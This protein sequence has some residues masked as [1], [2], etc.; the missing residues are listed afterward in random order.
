MHEYAEQPEK[1]LLSRKQADAIALVSLLLGILFFL[2]QEISSQQDKA[3]TE[4]FQTQTTATLQVQAHQIQNLTVLIEKALVQA[5]QAPEERFVVRERIATVRSKPE[6]GSIVEGKLMPNEVVR[7]I[8]R[9]GKW[10]E[11]EYYHWLHEEYRTG[12]VLKKYLERVPA[13]YAKARSQ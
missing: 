12:W 6:H 13:N 3:K 1:G 10:V 5:A 9:D 11:V 8:D 2:Y 7:A 4:A